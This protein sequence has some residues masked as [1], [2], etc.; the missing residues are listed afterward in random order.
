MEMAERVGWQKDDEVEMWKEQQSTFLMEA[1]KFE[2]KPVLKF[3]QWFPRLRGFHGEK[4]HF[5]SS[6]DPPTFFWFQSKTDFW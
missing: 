4:V 2:L 1:E 5:Q 6:R 3:N